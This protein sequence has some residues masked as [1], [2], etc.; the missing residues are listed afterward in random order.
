MLLL[1]KIPLPHKIQKITCFYVFK[2]P[3]AGSS[4]MFKESYY[5]NAVL[6]LYFFIFWNILYILIEVAGESCKKN[7]SRCNYMKTNGMILY[8]ILSNSCPR[9]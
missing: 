5:I 7:N 2:V 1:V 9:A 4:T 3:D 8:A 6:L